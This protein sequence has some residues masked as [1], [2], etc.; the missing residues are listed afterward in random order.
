MYIVQYDIAI[1]AVLKVALLKE[2][3]TVLYLYEIMIF[4]LIIPVIA[5]LHQLLIDVLLHIKLK[6][7]KELYGRGHFPII[8]K[9]RMP[10]RTLTIARRNLN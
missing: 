7:L 8:L 6:F 1:A 10:S 2:F 5:I 9:L 4:L 3:L